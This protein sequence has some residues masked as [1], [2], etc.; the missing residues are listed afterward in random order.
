MYNGY[1]F[2]ERPMEAI[3]RYNAISWGQDPD[4]AWEEYKDE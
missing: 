3:I 4:E 1:E 2:P